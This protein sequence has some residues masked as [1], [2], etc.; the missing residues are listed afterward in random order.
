MFCSLFIYI[1]DGE[2]RSE[3]GEEDVSEH[4]PGSK[5][6]SG[7]AKRDLHLEHNG[8]QQKEH[9][10]ASNSSQRQAR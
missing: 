2:K 9:K 5:E 1:V 6:T 7:A 4:Y 10:H 3:R 8:P